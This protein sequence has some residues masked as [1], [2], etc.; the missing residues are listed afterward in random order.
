MKVRWREGVMGSEGVK[1]E[2]GKGKRE[3]FCFQSTTQ[4]FI[5]RD[6]ESG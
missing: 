6:G 4:R 1:S 2:K 5:M 3:K